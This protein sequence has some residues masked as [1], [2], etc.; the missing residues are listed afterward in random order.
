M[1]NSH[2]GERPP[3]WGEVVTSICGNP[4]VKLYLQVCV[5]CCSQIR[6]SRPL[7]V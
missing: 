5:D 2:L 6:E 4:L 1:V 3:R 7:R